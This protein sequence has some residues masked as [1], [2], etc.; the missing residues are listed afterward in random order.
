MKHSALCNM[1]FF[2][3][4]LK[5]NVLGKALVEKGVPSTR[6]KLFHISTFLC[7]R[8]FSIEKT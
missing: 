6:L 5:T 1:Q 8:T 2:V 4:S 3:A 7:L